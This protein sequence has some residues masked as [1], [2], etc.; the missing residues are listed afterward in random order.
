M[1]I[2]LMP[3]LQELEV[4]R[5]GVRLADLGQR[6]QPSLVLAEEPVE[7]SRDQLPEWAAA[8]AAH[9]HQRIHVAGDRLVGDS[10]RR[11]GKHERRQQV[12]L[13]VRYVLR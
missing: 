8:P 11:P 1:D 9:L 5:Q 4:R 10:G 13:E 6:G 12:L 2:G 3:H 7:V